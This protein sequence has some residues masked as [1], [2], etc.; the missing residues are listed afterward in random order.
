LFGQEVVYSRN[1]VTKFDL[2]VNVTESAGRIHF[3]IN[4]S[5]RHYRPETI[6]QFLRNYRNILFYMP[7]HENGLLSDIRPGGLYDEV[8]FH[9]EMLTQDF[10]FQ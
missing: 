9:E 4:Y 1:R 6:G 10:N 2:I 5:P 7:E 8:E 3:G